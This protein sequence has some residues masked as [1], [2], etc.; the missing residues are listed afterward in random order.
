MKN[1]QSTF[2]RRTSQGFTLIEVMIAIVI[3]GTGLL[4]TAMIQLKNTQYSH[5]SLMRSHVSMLAVEIVER[6]RINFDEAI[7]GN[8]DIAIDDSTPVVLTDCETTTVQCSSEDL[9][10]FDLNQWRTRVETILPGGS[11]SILANA[12]IEPPSVTISIRRAVNQVNETQ[13]FVIGL[14]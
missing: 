1:F 12:T 4:G 6:M 13:T 10:A 14:W 9:A 7:G 3:L 5:S 11:A 2:S 8:Y